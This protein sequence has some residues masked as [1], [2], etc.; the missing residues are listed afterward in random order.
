MKFFKSVLLLTL[1]S[2]IFSCNRIDTSTP[3]IMLLTAS[4]SGN[5]DY[6]KLAIAKGANVNAKDEKGSTALHWATY[7]EHTD[8]IRFLLM[9]GANPYETD[10]YGVTPIDVARFNK[11]E[12]ALEI[13]KKFGY[14]KYNHLN[15]IPHK[16][17]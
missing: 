10:N 6:V 11:K 14:L 15:K 8:I 12:K 2:F 16:L 5:L 17:I 13:F 3:D 4:K 1:I 9:H 7:Y